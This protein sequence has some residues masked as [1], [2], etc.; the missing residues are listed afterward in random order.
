MSAIISPDEV[1][2]SHVEIYKNML[3]DVKIYNSLIQ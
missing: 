2:D 3:L 1:Y